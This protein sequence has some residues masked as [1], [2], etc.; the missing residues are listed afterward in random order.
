LA[1][2]ARYGTV[3][4]TDTTE[5]AQIATSILVRACAG[6]APAVASLD[7]D[8]A[9]RLGR[10]FDEVQRA[11]SLLAEDAAANWY[12]ALAEVAARRDAPALLSGR[13]VRLLFDVGRLDSEEVAGALSRALSSG[14]TPP[15]QAAWVEGLLSGDALLLIHDDQLL[16]VLDEWVVNLTDEAF[17]DVVPLVRRTFGS[18]QRPERRQVERQV[19]ALGK[20]SGALMAATANPDFEAVADVLAT[21]RV[22]LGVGHPGLEPGS[23]PES[24]LDGAEEVSYG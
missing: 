20:R 18:F 19:L 15:E 14:A 17:T 11:T 6:L 12:A 24:G 7:D 22:L 21:V 3:R 16:A 23:Q 8:A 2:A 10:L 1:R 5:L 13:A 4:G 9:R